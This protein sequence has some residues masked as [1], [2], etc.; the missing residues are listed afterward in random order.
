[1]EES[2]KR[3]RAELIEEINRHRKRLRI[4]EHAE[5]VPLLAQVETAAQ[6]RE[7][8]RE[9]EE[10]LRSLNEELHNLNVQLIRDGLPTN[11]P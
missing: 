6:V 3:R 5:R 10:K 2:A 7:M 9:V 8:R 11:A 4:L 1:M